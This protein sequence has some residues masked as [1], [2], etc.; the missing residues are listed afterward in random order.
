[1]RIRLILVVLGLLLIIGMLMI[2]SWRC[3]IILMSGLMGSREDFSSLGGA[4]VHLPASG[5]AFEN[6]VWGTVEEYGDAGLERCCAFLS[7]PGVFADCSAC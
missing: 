3:L 7:V 2:L 5:I 1:M 4:G 6:S